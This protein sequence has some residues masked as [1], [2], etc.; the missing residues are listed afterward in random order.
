V[1]VCVYVYICIYIYTC[2]HIYIWFSRTTAFRPDHICIYIL[3]GVH[4]RSCMRSL[5]ISVGGRGLW[6]SAS[7]YRALVAW[8]GGL[9]LIE[10]KIGVSLSSLFF[11]RGWECIWMY[12]CVY[13]HTRTHCTWGARM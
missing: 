4:A 3:Q 5:F 1:Y 7:L 2:I 8:R 6:V 11:S 9:L 12:V 13:A 10:G